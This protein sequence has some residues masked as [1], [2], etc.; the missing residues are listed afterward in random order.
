M[1]IKELTNNSSQELLVDNYMTLYRNLEKHRNPQ[2]ILSEM[3]AFINTPIPHTIKDKTI[4]RR[5][6]WTKL[7]SEN[8]EYDTEL[9]KTMTDQQLF[10]SG[11]PLWARG[12]QLQTI[13]YILEQHEYGIS[14]QEVYPELIE[15][16]WESFDKIK[17]F[18]IKT[19]KKA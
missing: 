12:L 11:N 19:L 15:S 6:I 16:F 3:E 14:M 2:E 8:P 9:A 18:K 5:T 4:Y 1:E 17:T 7:E 13:R 10:E